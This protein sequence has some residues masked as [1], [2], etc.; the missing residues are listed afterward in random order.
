MLT[1]RPYGAPRPLAR[2]CL[3]LLAL[4]FIGCNRH[5]VATT[6]PEAVAVAA[7]ERVPPD[8]FPGL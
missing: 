4:L 5:N 6:A 3:A 1:Q 7:P 2:T 8:Q